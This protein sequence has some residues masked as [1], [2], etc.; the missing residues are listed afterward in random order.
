MSINHNMLDDVKRALRVACEQRILNQVC[1]ILQKYSLLSDRES[2]LMKILGEDI[3]NGKTALILAA[4]TGDADIICVIIQTL[5]LTLQ[6][7]EIVYNYIR[8]SDQHGLSAIH[9]S[10][11]CGHVSCLSVLLF[12]DPQA[13]LLTNRNSATPYHLASSRNHHASMQLLMGLATP[14]ERK[15]MILGRRVRRIKLSEHLTDLFGKK[16]LESLAEVLPFFTHVA[17]LTIAFIYSVAFI[18]DHTPSSVE[19]L[20]HGCSCLTQFYVWWLTFSVFYSNPGDVHSTTFGEKKGKQKNLYDCTKIY[21]CCTSDTKNNDNYNNIDYETILTKM[22]EIILKYSL[23]SSKS[24]C[25]HYCRSY[26]PERAAHSFRLKKCIPRYDH[27]CYF[28]WRDIGEENYTYFIC[29]LLSMTTLAMPL[30][31]YQA[32]LYLRDHDVKPF[33]T[34]F[35]SGKYSFMDYLLQYYMV[36]TG[37]IW[38]FITLF[39]GFHIRL[40]F[41]G[42]TTR[43]FFLGRN[44]PIKIP[45]NFKNEAESPIRLVF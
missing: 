4:E 37:I 30:F 27:F 22:K 39:L 17:S 38:I 31:L 16:T 13:I 24:F 11:L 21:D 41:H 34:E 42:M 15:V 35:S 32:S 40:F 25:C 5:L 3:D 18:L 6:S 36:W 23:K 1:I 33:S 43:E 45:T 10:A 44:K 26:K 12:F 28:L 8:Q 9:W 29:Y 2:Y 14:L 19:I 20:S 7:K